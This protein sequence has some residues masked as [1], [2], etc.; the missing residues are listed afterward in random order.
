MWV[1][2]SDEPIPTY[3]M[4]SQSFNLWLC[5]NNYYGHTI[6]CKS[7]CVTAVWDSIDEC[8]YESK[9]HRKIDDRDIVHWWKDDQS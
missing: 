7:E 5:Y 6:F 2:I 4:H 8:F 1:N 9:T 3:G